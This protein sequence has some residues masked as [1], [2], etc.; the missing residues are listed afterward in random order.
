LL[1]FRKIIVLV[2]DLTLKSCHS[3]VSRARYIGFDMQKKKKSNLSN[4]GT[5]QQSGSN[6]NSD[7]ETKKRQTNDTG[8]K[9]D[10]D[11]NEWDEREAAAKLGENLNRE[12]VAV[13]ETKYQHKHPHNPLQDELHADPFKSKARQTKPMF[14][15]VNIHT[16]LKRTWKFDAFYLSLF[17]PQFYF[18]HILFLISYIIFSTESTCIC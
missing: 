9:T 5:F 16:R 12:L 10:H 8:D 1:T 4:S 18:L 14:E 2:N 3:L 17:L 15:P 11:D 13:E 6:K 7:N